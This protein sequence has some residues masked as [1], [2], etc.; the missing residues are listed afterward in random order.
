MKRILQYILRIFSKIILRKYKP[1]IV[2]ITGSVGKTSAKEAIYQVLG[3]YFRVRS[4]KRNYNNEIGVPLTIL[5]IEGGGGSFL[6]WA[7]VFLK[8]IRIIISGRDYPE[9]LV[10]EMGVDRPGDM[11]YLTGFV[12]VDAAVITA[13]GEF[14]THLEFFPEKD[15]LIGEKSI[16]AKS[17]VKEGLVVLNYDDISVRMMADGLPEGIKTITYGFGEGASIQ[18]SNYNFYLSDLD[19]GDYGAT[20][21]LEYEGSIVPFRVEKMIGKQQVFAVAAAAGVGMGFGL[22]LVEI[23]N[24]FKKMFNLP[25]RTNLIKGIKKSWVIDDTYNASPLATIAALGILEEIYLTADKPA[26][27]KIAVLGDML[28][29]GKDMEVAHRQVGQKAAGV[30]SLIFTVGGR[31]RF[32]ADE[33]IKSGFNKENVFE[34]DE[35]SAAALKLQEELKPEDIV[36]IKGSRSIHMEKAVKE[37]M[38]EPGKAD[39]LLVKNGF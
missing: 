11:A 20:F 28:E 25:G 38:A 21:K 29:L 8:A 17:V 12:P 5:G 15:E 23:S 26:A 24:A 34:F 10:L 19:K 16:L 36:L 4:N 39:E 22:N 6:L 32:I 35:P 37:I 1:E 3:K 2:A 30:A 7:K 9:I 13:I 33:A 18:I 14:P 27:R 31:A